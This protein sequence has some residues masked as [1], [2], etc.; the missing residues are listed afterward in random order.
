M[1]NGFPS[2]QTPTAQWWDYSRQNTGT[3][4]IALANDCA[5]VQY[6]ATGG[7]ATSIQVTLPPSPA[8]GKTITFKNE[9][10]GSSNTQTV[11]IND[12]APQG[13]QPP[14]IL[15]QG[16]S[17][18]FCYIVQNTIANVN[19]GATSNWVVISNGSGVVPYNAYSATVGGYNNNAAGLYSITAGGY[20]NKITP[21][22]GTTGG[23]FV[24]CGN[25]NT[26]TAGFGAGIIGSSSSTVTGN[27]SVIVGGGSNTISGGSCF[28]AGNGHNVSGN[29]SGALSGLSNTVSGQYS[30]VVAGAYGSSRGIQGYTASGSGNP[31]VSYT[32]GAQ[33]G[34]LVLGRVTTDA[35]PTLLTSDIS[36]TAS[37]TNQIILP[38]NSAYYFRG[39]VVCGVTA[40]GNSSAWSF[41]GLIKRGANAAATSIVQSV[42]NLVG[43]NSGASAWVVALT[44]DTTNGGL[45]VTV[46]GQASTT[47]RWVCTINTTEMNF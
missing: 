40:A 29:Y 5:P 1:F 22:Y 19:S 47:I 38:N 28:S 24:L 4:N 14:C 10:G 13:V 31:Y 26:V 3:I 11:S 33:A 12:P 17:V 42:V 39:S 43:Q 41:E 8:Q 45:S 25:G 20:N 23:A 30:A 9:N 21:G 37:S 18:T 6:F 46:T 32:I 16:G 35:T 34:Q 7:S 44:A 15:G 2:T 36:S 27:S